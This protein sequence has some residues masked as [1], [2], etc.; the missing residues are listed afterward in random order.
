MSINN[1]QVPLEKQES[2]RAILEVLNCNLLWI[3]NPTYSS[4][5]IIATDQ[6]IL[7]HYISNGYYLYDPNAVIRSYEKNKLNLQ[8]NITLGTDCKPFVTSGFLYDLNK[9]FN[10]EEFVSVEHRIGPE[11]YCYRFFTINNKFM[12]V[13]SLL[14][15]MPLIKTFI[16]SMVNS[17]QAS[18]YREVGAIIK[19]S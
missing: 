14:N 15:H 10:I 3:I 17:V 13:N 16:N 2:C 8:Y 4:L 19:I 9:M 12:F 5:N 18:V 11:I 1:L 7:N 6:C